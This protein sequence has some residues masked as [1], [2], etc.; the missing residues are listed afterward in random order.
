MTQ[1]E[2]ISCEDMIWYMDGEIN[3]HISG[4][5]QFLSN[6]KNVNERIMKGKHKFKGKKKGEVRLVGNNEETN[7]IKNVCFVRELNVN[8]LSF[9]TI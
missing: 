4:N 6:V 3:K 8:V 7:V 1:V 5:M 2:S 9:E